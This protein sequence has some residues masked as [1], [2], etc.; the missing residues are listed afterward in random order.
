VMLESL[1]RA[2][3]WVPFRAVYDAVQRGE[4]R[5]PKGSDPQAATAAIVRIMSVSVRRNLVPWLSR[6]H[7]LP[8]GFA[9]V[10]IRPDWPSDSISTARDLGPAAGSGH[11]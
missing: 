5:Y 10:E 9:P 2:Y 6:H 7:L 1:W 8:P 3:G 11:P 4:L